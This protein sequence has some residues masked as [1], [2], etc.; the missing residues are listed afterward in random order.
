MR[1][2][3]LT[4]LLVGFLAPCSSL[5]SQNIN[6]LSFIRP[7]VS[8]FGNYAPS[9]QLNDS[10]SFSEWQSGLNV[11][12]PIRTRFKIGGGILDGKGKDLVK[13]SFVLANFNARYRTASTEVA[14]DLNPLLSLSA[15]VTGVKFSLRKGIWVYSFG[16]GFVEEMGGFGGESAFGYG[17][18]ARLK[19]KGLRKLNAY[20]LALVGG[21]RFILPIPLIGWVRTF[22]RKRT[23]TVVLPLF[24]RYTKKLGKRG[25]FRTDFNVNGYAAGFAAEP[26]PFYSGNP[27]SERLR[28][29]HSH[30]RWTVG[31][32]RKSGKGKRWLFGLDAGL[33]FP[34]SLRI[35]D[36]RE[37]LYQ[38][39]GLG[40][41][42]ISGTIR[43]RLKM[44]GLGNFLKDLG[45]FL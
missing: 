1:T 40:T 24:V 20:G 44:K 13:G 34:T 25:M 3:F 26:N 19:I 4:V 38:G 12:I 45:L 32:Y 29:S 8:V 2:F 7:R 17:A 11:T 31:L 35:Q 27:V 18:F 9:Y 36:G 22:K 10:V 21:R 6:L 41:P 33:N 42:Y 43:Y 28:L 5:F 15:G 23:L 30:L 37:N 16:G 14:S 39:N